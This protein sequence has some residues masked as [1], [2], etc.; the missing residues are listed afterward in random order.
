MSNLSQRINEDKK[1]YEN[2]MKNINKSDN[3]PVAKA[4]AKVVT[5]K[6][7]R[8]NNILDGPAIEMLDKYGFY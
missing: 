4:K 8:K 3:A 2:I 1:Q 6:S 7:S 5:K